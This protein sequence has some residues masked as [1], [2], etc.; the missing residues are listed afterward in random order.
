M[1]EKL[2]VRKIIWTILA[3]YKQEGSPIILKTTHTRDNYGPVWIDS[4]FAAY[5]Q[6]MHKLTLA[7]FIE[8]DKMTL[9][10]SCVCYKLF[11]YTIL[12]NLRKKA[13][14]NCHKLFSEVLPNHLKK[15]RPVDKF[16]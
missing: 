16:K 4:L 3:Q 8:K 11:L 2:H 14:E 13:C 1:N 9:N 10:C 12:E 7:I 6:L 15:L 5:L